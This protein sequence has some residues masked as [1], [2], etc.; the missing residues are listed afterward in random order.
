[1]FGLLLI[2]VIIIFA[3]RQRQRWR[4][5]LLFERPDGWESESGCCGHGDADPGAWSG[6]FRSRMRSKAWEAE[7]R[8]SERFA[9]RA[10]RF[11]RKMRRRFDHQTERWS[12]MSADPE[13]KDR[14]QFT[15]DE[16]RRAYQRARRRA[17]AKAGFYVHM[18]WYG[19]VIS[20]LFLINLMTTSFQWWLFP[21]VGWGFGLFSHFAAVFGWR[22]IHEQVFEP[23]I[24]RE[25]ER[26]VTREREVLRTE[27]Q[28]SLD[29]LTATFAHEIRN[30][31]AAAR[32]LVQQMG[33]DPTSAENVEYAKV[34]LDE[35]ARV[36]RSVSHLLKYAKQEDYH[37]EN[38][39]LASVLDGALS[40]M[41]SKIEA[42]SVVVSRNYLGGPLVRADADK[43]QSVF[44]NI[45]DN[46]IDATAGTSSERRI[47][48]RIERGRE[49]MA[50][51]KIRD[52]GCGIAREQL[53][54]IFNPFYTS[55]ERGTG[56]G[57]GVARKIV[58]AHRGTIEVASEPGAGAEFAISIPLARG[59]RGGEQAPPDNAPGERGGSAQA[60][61]ANGQWRGQP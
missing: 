46:A 59:A 33:E 2:A 43:L 41:R 44:T 49:A 29:E 31:I 55:K 45:V 8:L 47:E 51:V 12:G 37:F 16:Q 15:D 35:L 56:L 4:R 7:R 61:A 25:V 13:V 24:Q 22:W 30:P 42:N 58:D 48:L 1:M 36:E 20:S 26:E 50:T 32:S 19:L 60:A 14:Q 6:Q 9:R 17:A 39:N 21:A 28:A 23:A 11:E 27:K 34:A 38:V 57:L 18:M 53:G 52:N 3:L 54:K 10:E 40:Q 5:A